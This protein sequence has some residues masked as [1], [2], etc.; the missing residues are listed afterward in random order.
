MQEFDTNASDLNNQMI[1]DY[2]YIK[3]ISSQLRKKV[4]TF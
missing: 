1:D 4:K 3:C 2:V